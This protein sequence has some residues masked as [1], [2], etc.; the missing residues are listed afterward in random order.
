MLSPPQTTRS[1]LISATLTG[2]MGASVTWLTAPSWMAAS[3]SMQQDSPTM[4]SEQA[5]PTVYPSRPPLLP[6][7]PV[8]PLSSTIWASTW[9]VWWRRVAQVAWVRPWGPW[10]EVQHQTCPQAAVRDTP[11]SPPAPPHGWMRWTIPSFESGKPPWG[12]IIDIFL[13]FFL[14]PSDTGLFD[15]VGWRGEKKC[16]SVPQL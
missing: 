10:Q 7:C 8:T 9:T 2:C 14:S 1:C 15:D 4:T 11:T 12:Y 6:L 3:L 5:V 16:N 13:H